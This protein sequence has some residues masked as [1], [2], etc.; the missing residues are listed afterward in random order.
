MKIILNGDI[1]KITS[2]TLDKLLIELKIDNKVVTAINKI[3]IPCNKR[4]NIILKP[5]DEIEILTP[6]QGG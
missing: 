3:F 2:N 4:K 6:M 1:I 5:N